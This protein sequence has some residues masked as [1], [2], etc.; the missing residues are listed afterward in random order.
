VQVFENKGKRP[1]CGGVLHPSGMERHLCPWVEGIYLI[2]GIA[3][4]ITKNQLDI[5]FISNELWITEAR[6]KVACSA[7]FI[8]Y[9]GPFARYLSGNPLFPS[10]Y[11]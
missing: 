9:H 5:K 8:Y 1:Q 6:K 7:N 10:Q 2:V 3:Y 4:F 11:G